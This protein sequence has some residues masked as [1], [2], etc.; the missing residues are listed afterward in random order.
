M[1]AVDYHHCVST[2]DSCLL[3]SGFDFGRAFFA[4]DVVGAVNSAVFLVSI[5]VGGVTVFLVSMDVGGVTV[6]LVSMDV[7][8]CSRPSRWSDERALCTQTLS[9][10][11][12]ERY[13]VMYSRCAWVSYLRLQLLVQTQR[14]LFTLFPS[15]GGGGS[16]ALQMLQ[17]QQL[18]S[19]PNMH[20]LGARPPHSPPPRY[21]RRGC[22]V[23]GHRRRFAR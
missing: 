20:V 7:G 11:Q 6:F 17:V 13:H 16:L 14:T 10:V 21:Q 4:S 22:V 8:R 1:C 9:L 5:D 15:G 18:G 3:S 2:K 12:T 23:P 19:G